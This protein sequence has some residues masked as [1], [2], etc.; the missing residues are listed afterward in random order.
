MN[1]DD[2]DLGAVFAEVSQRVQARGKEVASYLQ[3]ESD[4]SDEAVGNEVKLFVGHVAKHG[5]RQYPRRHGVRLRQAP[6]WERG[7][8]RERLD[9]RVVDARLDA[10]LRQRGLHVAAGRVLR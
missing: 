9:R 1:L 3:G 8:V 2:R 10:F 5:Q 6:L 4:R 7:V